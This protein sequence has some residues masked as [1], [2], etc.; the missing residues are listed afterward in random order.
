M[1]LSPLI[2]TAKFPLNHTLAGTWSGEKPLRSIR[3]FTWSECQLGWK[4]A[5]GLLHSA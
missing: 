2:I 3:V 1:L 5:F 4:I